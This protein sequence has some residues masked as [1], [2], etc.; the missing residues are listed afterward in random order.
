MYIE[1]INVKIF[2]KNKNFHL[3]QYWQ[4]RAIYLF[5]FLR[6]KFEIVAL[7]NLKNVKK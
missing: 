1:D 2:F 5:L 6:L 7:S 4:I 3:V